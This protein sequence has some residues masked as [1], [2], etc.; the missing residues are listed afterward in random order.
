MFMGV[1]SGPVVT[2]LAPLATTKLAAI[3][4]DN[5]RLH[6]DACGSST[7]R[8]SSGAYGAVRSAV[9]TGN[10]C[11]ARSIVG[12]HTGSTL[13]WDQIRSAVV[14]DPLQLVVLH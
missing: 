10:G 7:V 13:F 6:I 14:A 3:S 9:A 11:N 2:R 5:C 4:F 1:L 8:E 12:E